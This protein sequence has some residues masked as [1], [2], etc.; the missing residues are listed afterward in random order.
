MAN[1][2]TQ[3]ADP[4]IAVEVSN[5]KVVPLSPSEIENAAAQID[6]SKY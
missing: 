2:S 1:V 3:L 6:P 4:E 5:S